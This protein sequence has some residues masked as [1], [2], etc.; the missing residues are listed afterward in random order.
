[1]YR[2]EHASTGQGKFNE[3]RDNAC[4]S[5]LKSFLIF[6]SVWL[7][8]ETG[9]I[10]RTRGV[11]VLSVKFVSVI[12]QLT[13]G[14]EGLGKVPRAPLSTALRSKLLQDRISMSFVFLQPELLIT[15][16]GMKSNRLEASVQILDQLNSSSFPGRPALRHFLLPSPGKK[17]DCPPF[18]LI[19]S[20]LV[21]KSH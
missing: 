8:T 9:A 15:F 17:D 5:S 1:M 4:Y 6:R 11:N 14:Q 21:G 7:R 18:Q 10:L 13:H 20:K 16:L 2:H 3:R 12:K 19:L